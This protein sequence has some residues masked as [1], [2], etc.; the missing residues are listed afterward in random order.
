MYM[1]VCKTAEVNG[2]YVLHGN[3][4]SFH[5]DKQPTFKAVY[6]AFKEVWCFCIF[7]HSISLTYVNLKF[8]IVSIL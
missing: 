8:I 3:R 5:N 2:I 4:G 6:K 7:Y 1:S